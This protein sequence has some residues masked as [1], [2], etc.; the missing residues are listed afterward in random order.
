MSVWKVKVDC[1]R[2]NG[3]R[4]RVVK[5]TLLIEADRSADAQVAAIAYLEAH[6]DIFGRQWLDM[7]WRETASVQ[8]PMELP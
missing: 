6:P 4:Q 8:F 5:K 3:K 1:L 7:E 2:M